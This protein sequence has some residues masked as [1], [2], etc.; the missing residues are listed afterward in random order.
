MRVERRFYPRYSVACLVQLRVQLDD[1]LMEL[2][3]HAIN[4][5]QSGVQLRCDQQVIDCLL[6][7]KSFP[8][9]CEMLILL[10]NGKTIAIEESRLVVNRR[11][12]QQVYHLGFNFIDLS[13]ENNRVLV[14][15]IEQLKARENSSQGTES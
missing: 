14:G 4:L 6:S 3:G 10:P 5:S 15:Y 11:L 1:R 12:T 9:A 7:Q 13:E 8:V 2:S